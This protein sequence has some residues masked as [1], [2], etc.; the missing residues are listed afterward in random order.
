MFPFFTESQQKHT[1]TA[2]RLFFLTMKQVNVVV[3]SV[4]LP[5]CFHLNQFCSV[6]WKHWE[7]E[8]GCHT[9]ASC[10]IIHVNRNINDFT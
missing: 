2:A 6:P 8:Y 4:I 7:A 10:V 5:L 1:N 9:L 3:L